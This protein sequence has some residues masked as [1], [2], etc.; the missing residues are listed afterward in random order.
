MGKDQG[1]VGTPVGSDQKEP[2]EL[3]R[4]IEETRQDLGD[5]AAALAQKTDI[6]ARARAKAESVK[7]T[8][9][10]KKEAFAQKSSGEDGNG[11]SGPTAQA[12]S[13]AI[14]LKTKAQENPTVAAAA[15]AFVG[16]YLFGRITSH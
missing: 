13:A 7:H 15:A 5:T 1:Q 6:K 8:V 3:R 11:A 9:A 16:G 2:E 4:E 14:Q 10:Q 12:S